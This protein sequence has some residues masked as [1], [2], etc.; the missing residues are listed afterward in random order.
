MKR[1]GRKWG[2]SFEFGEL[3]VS[4]GHKSEDFKKVI[5]HNKPRVQEKNLG[6]KIWKSLFLGMGV[7]QSLCR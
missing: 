4:L 3:V 7:L 1:E 6:I 2:L 5:G